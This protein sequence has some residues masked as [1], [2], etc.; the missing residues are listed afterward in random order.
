MKLNT[1]QSNTLPSIFNFQ[2]IRPGKIFSSAFFAAT[3]TINQKMPGQMTEIWTNT[4]NFLGRAWWVEVMTAQ[5]KCLYYF[6][7][8]ADAQE[9]AVAMEGYV[10]DLENESSQGIQTQIKRCKPDHLTIEYDQSD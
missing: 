7:P 5:P 1:I 9:A 3:M 10:E 6:G 8:F 2:T 4:L